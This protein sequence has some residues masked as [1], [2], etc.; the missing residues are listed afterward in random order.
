MA[1]VFDTTGTTLYKDGVN[2]ASS[3]TAKSPPR[4]LSR[5]LVKTQE[6]SA[7]RIRRHLHTISMEN[8]KRSQFYTAAFTA[9]EVQQLYMEF[10]GVKVAPPA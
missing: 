9:E 6:Y 10:L 3:S 7:I 5:S 4:V 8:S 1:A 2:I